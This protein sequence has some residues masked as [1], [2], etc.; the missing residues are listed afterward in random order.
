MIIKFN[1]FILSPINNFTTKFLGAY[2][3]LYFV[4]KSNQNKHN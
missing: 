4:P 1:N 2:K 3:F